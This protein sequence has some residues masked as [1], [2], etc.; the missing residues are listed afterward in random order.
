MKLVPGRTHKTYI[1]AAQTLITQMILTYSGNKTNN[2]IK[3]S[4]WV[5]IL[6]SCTDSHMI[7]SHF[8][9]ACNH[10]YIMGGADDNVNVN[11]A[12]AAAEVIADYE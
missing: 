9:T 4:L 11:N 7:K 1:P 10:K 5:S 6:Y 2:K 3:F 8:F 12:A